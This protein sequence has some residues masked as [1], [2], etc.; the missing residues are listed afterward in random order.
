MNTLTDICLLYIPISDF[1]TCPVSQL[2]C[3]S[4]C[5][6]LKNPHCSMAMTAVHTS[7]FAVLHRYCNISMSEKEWTI[8]PNKQKIKETSSKCIKWGGDTVCM[9]VAILTSYLYMYLCGHIPLYSKYI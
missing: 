1:H 8:N 7:K 3:H 2:V 5:G 6:T 4:R 9:C